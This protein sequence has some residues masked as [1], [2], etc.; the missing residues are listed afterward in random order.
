MTVGRD[1]RAADLTERATLEALATGFADV[2]LPLA[3]SGGARPRPRLALAAPLPRG[4]RAEA[5]LIE[6]YL[7]VRL[8]VEAA[9]RLVVAGLPAG[10][11]LIDLE[12]EWAGAPSLVSRVVAL[13][14]RAE[15]AARDSL[16]R[17]DVEAALTSRDAGASG[18]HDTLASRGVI[19]IE[20]WDEEARRGTLILRVERDEAGRLARPG[21]TI[22]ALGLGLHQVRLVRTAIELTGGSA[23]R[24][25]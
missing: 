3:M 17:G 2:G 13:E 21:E 1:E 5:D 12:D 18:S 25:R 16:S 24:D 23:R 22:E 9:R 19:A 6:I 20:E 10:F 8:P 14:Y 7:S 15:V 4:A 11:W